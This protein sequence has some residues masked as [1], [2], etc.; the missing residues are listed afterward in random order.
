M[1]PSSVC[2]RVTSPSK[3]NWANVEILS[4]VVLLIIGAIVGWAGNHFLP[5]LWRRLTGRGAV[6][7]HVETDPGVFLAGDPNWDAF[8]YLIPT[9]LSDLGPPPSHTCRDWHAWATKQGGTPAGWSRVRLTLSGHLDATVLV[10][11][12]SVQ[13]RKRRPHGDGLYVLCRTGGADAVPRG[14]SV[15]LDRDPP[16][17]SHVDT[18]GEPIHAPLAISVA[19]GEVEI[20]EIEARATEGVVEW[21]AELAIVVNGKRK[22]VPVTD[23]RSGFVTGGT[24]GFSPYEWSG[25]E[26][27][28]VNLG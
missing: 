4:S 1:V 22:V 12:L 11:R 13:I 5:L 3:S 25:T 7:I 24:R 28:E 2:S 6:D 16:W 19:K 9:P 26:W 21:T 10:D 27:Q 20:F 8:G 23:G 18:S 15:D 14:F 17:V